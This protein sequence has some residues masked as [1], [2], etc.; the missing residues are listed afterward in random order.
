MN[1]RHVRKEDL[2][3]LVRLENTGF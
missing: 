1:I 2:N 3:Q